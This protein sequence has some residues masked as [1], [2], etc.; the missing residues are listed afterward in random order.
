MKQVSVRA[1]RPIAALLVLGAAA[2]AAA[3]DT[4]EPE[5]FAFEDE[6]ALYSLARAEFIG[7]AAAY[8]FIGQRPVV[9]EGTKPQDPYDF[10]IAVTEIDGAFHVLPAGMFEGF[11]INP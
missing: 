2:L 3:C 1:V 5:W 6:V 7:R 11:P 8:D 10:D 9:V 4:F